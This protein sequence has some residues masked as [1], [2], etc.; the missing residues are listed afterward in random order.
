MTD[1]DD[2]LH[3][4]KLY[5]LTT[6]LPLILYGIEESQRV[7]VRPMS[8]DERFGPPAR[9]GKSTAGDIPLR[10]MAIDRQIRER[11]QVDIVE[12]SL[13]RLFGH[14]RTLGLAVWYEYVNQWDEYEGQ[15]RRRL[16][17]EGL[18]WMADDIEEELLPYTPDRLPKVVREIDRDKQIRKLRKKGW[19]IRRLA[20]QYG[21]SPRQIRHIVN[22]DKHKGMSQWQISKQSEVTA[23]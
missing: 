18:E 12:A 9:G 22:G 14:S 13:V 10:A 6:L 21:L 7:T 3:D 15:R 16:A 23:K 4:E 8:P 19:P 11:W 5:A 1:R 17:D 20:N 2:R